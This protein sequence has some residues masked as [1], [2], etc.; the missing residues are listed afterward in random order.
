MQAEVTRRRRLGR[1]VV[2]AVLVIA[3]PGLFVLDTAVAALRGHD[4]SGASRLLFSG[5]LA[6]CI[7]VPLGLLVGR[8]RAWFDR[9]GSKLALL[10]GAV[11][12]S[13][14]CAEIALK[15]VIRPVPFHLRQAGL[16]TVFHPD[17]R[18]VPGISGESRF[19][20]NSLGI[21]GSE[22]PPR[23]E[24]HR[25]LCI[26]GSTTE[27]LYLDDRKTWPE[28]LM[29]SLNQTAE[30]RKVWVGNAGLSGFDSAHHLRLIRDH[31]FIRQF[32]CVVL[33]VGFN[34]LARHLRGAPPGMEFSKPL[35]HK[36]RLAAL[37]HTQLLG[38]VHHDQIGANYVGLRNRR[39]RAEK[40]NVVPDLPAGLAKYRES[41]RSIIETC[42]AEG[43]RCVLITQ[44]VLWDRNNSP[45]TQSLLWLG[46]MQD[47][48]Y[49]EAGRAREAMN[50]YNTTLQEVA[51]ETGTA[52]VDLTSLSGK[53]EFFYD[54]CHFTEAG[55]Q[56]VARL[57]TKHFQ[58]NTP[59]PL[60]SGG[61]WIGTG[62]DHRE[63]K[64]QG[65]G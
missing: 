16:E 46:D 60:K 59:G 33:M 28:I 11:V 7:A 2:L 39:E 48:R 56:E 23:N 27:C 18:Y 54:D 63:L 64:K 62:Q 65:A 41:L 50:A 40:G 15:L 57:L 34:D 21:R 29:Q 52:I 49:L 1:R 25:I 14:V 24:A 32:D 13:L 20:V 55:A 43:I 38:G 30:R 45:E 17:S 53:V 22:L 19:R 6:L 58:R 3:A 5:M 51:A 12:L 44:P 26:G 36:T 61:E 10:C 8:I 37:V 35:W 47:G 4:M 9:H 31:D 42:R